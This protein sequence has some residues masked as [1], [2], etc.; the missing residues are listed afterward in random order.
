M[1]GRLNALDLSS[2][3]ISH[4]DAAALDLPNLEYVS[5][6]HND[7]SSVAAGVFGEAPSEAGCGSATLRKLL[8]LYQTKSGQLRAA[9]RTC[10]W[11]VTE[12]SSLAKAMERMTSGAASS[13]DEVAEDAE[14]RA[15]VEE[16]AGAASSPARK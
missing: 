5:L 7:L 15:D 4:I 16:E 1:Q 2:N 13:S 9:P 8:T 11:L 10:E 12:A 6:V 3:N 14:L